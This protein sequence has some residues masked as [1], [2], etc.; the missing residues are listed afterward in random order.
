MADQADGEGIQEEILVAP[1]RRVSVRY[2]CTRRPWLIRVLAKPSFQSVRAIVQEISTTG[3]SLALA[4]K[5]PE[6][7][8]LAIEFRGSASG[9]SG[10]VSGRVVHARL[11]DCGNWIIG[12]Q[13]ARPLSESDL[14]ALLA[15]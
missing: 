12:C 1:N 8:I 7:T 15:D 9:F 2:P 14:D 6:G 5:V 4:S 11:N 3:L 13:L 10:I